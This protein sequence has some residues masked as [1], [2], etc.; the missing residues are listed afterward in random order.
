[1]QPARAAAG[2]LLLLAFGCGRDSPTA[3]PAAVTTPR[4]VG[5]VLADSLNV[6]LAGASLV[7]TSLFDV[8]GF[9]LVLTAATDAAGEVELQMRP[10]PWIVS[11]RVQDGRVA[12]GQAVILAPPPNPDSVLVR[13]VA[14]A[15]SRIEGHATLAGRT[16]HRG[17]LVNALGL[18]GA[19]AVTDS[20]GA[21]VLDHVPLGEWG[22]F[23]GA[24]GFGDQFTSVG[25][26]T[27]GS[28]VIAPDVQLISAPAPAPRPPT[29]PAAAAR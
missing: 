21:Y 16:D 25:V 5:I 10:G 11:A 26:T 7:A 3:P 13:L 6:P 22:L 8:N 29:S 1:M 2:I 20:S 27:P 19:L 24:L 18:D 4:P 23:F 17:I 12:A 15:P 14:H 28:V 9:A